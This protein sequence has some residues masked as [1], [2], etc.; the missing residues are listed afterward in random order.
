MMP[1]MAGTPRSRA[2]STCASCV[3]LGANDIV[4]T[5]RDSRYAPQLATCTSGV[6]RRPDRAA[7]AQ[8]DAG[9]RG[10][11]VDVPVGAVRE[12][13]PAA[14]E[15]EHVAVP[16]DP[17]LHA[18]LRHQLLVRRV[19]VPRRVAA[20][21]PPERRAVAPRRRDEAPPPL[22]RRG[23]VPLPV[24]EPPPRLAQRPP[25]PL[26]RGVLRVPRV[27]R[28]D[29]ARRRRPRLGRVLLGRAVVDREVEGGVV[30]R[31]RG[32]RWLP[33]VARDGGEGGGGE[34][35]GRVRPHGE[36]VG[37]GAE[38]HDGGH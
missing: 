12:H 10:D 22:G 28:R 13:G 21:R 14:G 32:R 26:A 29:A 8:R 18:L 25:L 24:R 35:R 3:S 31:G 2:K 5:S 37:G 9:R 1:S 23:A 33:R 17:V 27:A 20:P 15:A 36:E 19:R 30:L 38:R 34:R 6:Q 4:S 11:V 16:P 7:A